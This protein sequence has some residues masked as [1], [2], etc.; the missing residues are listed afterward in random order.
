M[1]LILDK[2]EDG[3]MTAAVVADSQKEAVAEAKTELPVGE[4][5]LAKVMSTLTLA[6]PVNEP[7]VVAHVQTLSPRKRD[8]A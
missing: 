4:Y 2:S 7:A 1:Y 5:Y 6:P 3:H 8:L